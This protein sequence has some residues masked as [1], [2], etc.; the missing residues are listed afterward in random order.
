MAR[1][2]KHWRI[3]SE[4]TEVGTQG[5]PSDI[6][7]ATVSV[8]CAVRMLRVRGILFKSV[9]WLNK[10]SAEDSR[11]H[12]VI[13]KTGTRVKSLLVRSQIIQYVTQINI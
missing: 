7:V 13:R 12:A 6:P 8:I 1:V 10:S 5:I 2:F 9:R 3:L 11:L 4:V